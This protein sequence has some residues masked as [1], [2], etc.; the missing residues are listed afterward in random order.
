MPPGEA[1]EGIQAADRLRETHP[2]V[3]VVVLSQYANPSY[4]LALL[5]RAPQGARTC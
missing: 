5:R 2:E 1:D 4:V 3:G